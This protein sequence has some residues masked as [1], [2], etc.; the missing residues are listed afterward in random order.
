MVRS[1]TA[2]PQRRKLNSVRTKAGS[3]S[4]RD[5]A[6]AVLAALRHGATL[7]RAAHENGISP[8]TVRRYVGSALIQDRP[9][10]RVRATKSDRL[11]RYLQIPGADGSPVNITAR[12]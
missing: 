8:R 1:R 11:V 7:S 4:T 6:F 12:G 2:K 5:R 10:G 3:E 9:G